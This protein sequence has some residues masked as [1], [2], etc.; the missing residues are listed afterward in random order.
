[1]KISIH[2]ALAVGVTVLVAACAGLVRG[3]AS[4][5]NLAPAAGP[6]PQLAKVQERWTLPRGVQDI[7]VVA[8]ESAATALTAQIA[9]FQGTNVSSTAPAMT[10]VGALQSEGILGGGPYDSS[11]PVLATSASGDF[12]AHFPG[13]AGGP[14]IVEHFRQLT[15]MA[16]PVNGAVLAVNLR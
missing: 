3:T 7:P 14:D 16:A 1:M 5:T 10:T 2:I 15:V 11:D 13:K 8:R 6:A 9:R 4:S 12:V